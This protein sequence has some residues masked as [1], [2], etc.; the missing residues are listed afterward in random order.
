MNGFALS[1]IFGFMV[2]GILVGFVFAL[3]KGR[4]GI[5][6]YFVSL[7]VGIGAFYLMI[8]VLDFAAREIACAEINHALKTGKPVRAEI[9]NTPYVHRCGVDVTPLLNR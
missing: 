5:V 3:E 8:Q 7:M 6:R 4:R 2:A 9:L 1:L